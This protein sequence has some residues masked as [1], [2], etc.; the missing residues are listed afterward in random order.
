VILLHD[1]ARPH[2]TW[3][4]VETVNSLGLEV[5]PYPPYSPDLATSDY[6]LFGLM[7]KMLGGQKF[8]LD[9]E[10]QFVSGLLSI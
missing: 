10:V 2:T 7:K 4:T 5:L 8:A 3:V 1:N 9:M 6:H